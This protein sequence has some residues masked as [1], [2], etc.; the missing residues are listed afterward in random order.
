MVAILIGFSYSVIKTAEQPISAGKITF[1]FFA[2]NS[3]IYSQ[4]HFSK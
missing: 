3:E 4:N 1:E 2:F